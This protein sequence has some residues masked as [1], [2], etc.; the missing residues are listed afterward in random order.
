MKL[1]DEPIEVLDLVAFFIDDP[2]DLLSLALSARLFADIV[3]PDHIRFRR[4]RCKPDV[5]LFKSLEQRPDIASKLREITICSSL[6]LANGFKELFIPTPLAGK[7]LYRSP[8]PSII[9][10]RTLRKSKSA[11]F[12][13]VLNAVVNPGNQGLPFHGRA[14]NPDRTSLSPNPRQ[15][16]LLNANDGELLLSSLANVILGMGFLR[17]FCL[18]IS[19]QPL[20]GFQNLFE[21]LRRECSALEE[22]HI[23]LEIPFGNPPYPLDD[24]VK[25][26]WG[27]SNL[28]ALFLEIRHPVDPTVPSDYAEEMVGM[29]LRCKELRDLHLCVA[30]YGEGLIRI[31]RLLRDG[32]WDQLRRLSIDGLLCL[33]EDDSN[34]VENGA[35]LSAFYR[36]HPKLEAIEVNSSSTLFVPGHV[37]PT[38]LPNLKDLELKM[39]AYNKVDELIP[40]DVCRNLV[41]LITLTHEVSVQ[42]LKQMVHLRIFGG[43][44]DLDD[45]AGLAD[46]LPNIERLH[47][48]SAVHPGWDKTT[49]C[50]RSALLN[51]YLDPVL[52]L[53]KLTH[54]TGLLVYQTFEFRDFGKKTNAFSR[55]A[56]SLSRLEC[57]Q[58]RNPHGYEQTLRFIRDEHER[59]CGFEWE[60]DDLSNPTDGWGNFFRGFA[61]K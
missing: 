33:F 22:L 53:K 30:R 37:D 17:R 21:T 50:F 9:S 57:V 39:F 5:G 51:K 43:M 34:V 38:S 10:Q 20:P 25:P 4:L 45:L 56:S 7:K 19:T 35:V 41:C 61:R 60:V 48:R 42:L 14:V 1:I 40:I 18:H 24:I 28:T 49:P 27:F 47:V 11:S 13:K 8:A 58:V 15:P 54:L 52:R 29:V 26:M 36:R 44:V 16:G 32:C 55:L 46:A 12:R 3:I 59:C 23:F 2:A 31:P 6:G